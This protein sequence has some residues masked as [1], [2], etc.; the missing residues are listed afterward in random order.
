MPYTDNALLISR[1]VVVA[2][3][4]TYDSQK[5]FLRRWFPTWYGDHPAIQALRRHLACHEGDFLD[6]HALLTPAFAVRNRRDDYSESV[7]AS[8]RTLRRL[9]TAAS[10]SPDIEKPEQKSLFYFLYAFFAFPQPRNYFDICMRFLFSDTARFNG[11]VNDRI[12]S[13][14]TYDKLAKRSPHP[15]S[16]IGHYNG[17]PPVHDSFY[18]HIRIR[19]LVNNLSGRS[20]DAIKTHPYEGLYSWSKGNPLISVENFLVFLLDKRSQALTEEEQNSFFQNLFPGQDPDWTPAPTQY[21]TDVSAITHFVNNL[22]YAKNAWIFKDERLY[23]ALLQ[24][25][26]VLLSYFS[27]LKWH[28]KDQEWPETLIPKTPEQYTD[29]LTLLENGGAALAAGGPEQAHFFTNL[30][31]IT[32]AQ[33]VMRSSGFSDESIQQVSKLLVNG[34]WETWGERLFVTRERYGHEILRNCPEQIVEH[35]KKVNYFPSRDNPW[36]IHQNLAILLDS[37]QEEAKKDPEATKAFLETLPERYQILILLGKMCVSLKSGE[38]QKMATALAQAPLSKESLSKFFQTMLG[39]RDS[40]RSFTSAPEF[41]NFLSQNP[42]A[43]QAAFAPVM[44]AYAE[45]LFRAQRSDMGS[46]P[47]CSSRQI[48]AEET[49]VLSGEDGS[50]VSNQG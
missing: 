33:M 31:K 12:A 44:T 10:I 30:P 26:A 15:S 2:N 35:L 48:Q 28:G 41:A 29:L 22:E 25:P 1:A 43:F 34:G 32:K 18:Q 7:K 24:S 13:L 8:T 16:F 40:G 21:R 23:P 9:L 20:Y 11:D 4:A 50:F 46:Q 49:S 39:L 17:L 47:G 19:H 6:V 36:P 3:L 27:C 14:G 5:G 38:M 37:R 45:I 42:D